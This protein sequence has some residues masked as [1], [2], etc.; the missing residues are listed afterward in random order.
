MLRTFIAS[1][2]FTFLLLSGCTN[3]GTGATCDPTCTSLQECCNGT[4]V[5]TQSDTNNCG[6]CGAICQGTCANGVCVPDSNPGVDAS[7]PD[8]DAGTMSQGECRPTCAS[9]QRCC[10]RVCVDRQQPSGAD[11]RPATADDPSSTFNNCGACGVKCDPERASSCSLRAGNANPQCACGEFPACQGSDVCAM[12]SSGLRCLN[13]STNPEHCGEIGNA[14]AAG[15][16]CTGGV[17]GCG[18]AGPCAEGEACCGGTCTDVTSDAMHCGGCGMACG[19][20]APN[21]VAG[22]CVCGTGPEAR[23]C[24]A[25]TAGGIFNPGGDPGESCCDGACVPNDDDSCACS[26]C[27]GEEECAVAAPL[28]GS[29]PVEV[30][31]TDQPALL[32]LLGCGG[33]GLP[34]P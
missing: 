24:T 32:P 15:E 33:G 34:F 8:R 7:T 1:A 25:P 4:C 31:C 9:S 29:G 27:T 5:F 11:G 14:C 12:T 23:V 30:C 22:S 13:T 21:C 2:F 17:C 20:N 10:G 16:T 3:T 6:V 19:A 26:A 18:G 28:T